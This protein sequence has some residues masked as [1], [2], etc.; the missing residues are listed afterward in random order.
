MNIKNK[1]GNKKNILERKIS[2][3]IKKCSWNRN[4]IDEDDFHLL[5]TLLLSLFFSACEEKVPF[6]VYEDEG[7][8]NPTQRRR[9]A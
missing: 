8:N 6:L 9:D 1:L 5:L 4:Q 2:N 7:Q 3:N